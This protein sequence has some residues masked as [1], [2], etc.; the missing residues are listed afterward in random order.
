MAA[1]AAAAGGGG[2]GNLDFLRNSP[3]FQAFRAMV[4]ANPQILQVFIILSIYFS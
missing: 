4:Q 2:G 3:Q 1:N